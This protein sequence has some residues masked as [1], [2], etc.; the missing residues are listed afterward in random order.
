MAA[1]QSAKD[2]VRTRV[3]R[4]SAPLPRSARPGSTKRCDASPRGGSVRCPA[5]SGCDRAGCRWP[6][7]PARAR[8][9][10]AAAA[11]RACPGDGRARRAAAIQV[12]RRA[13]QH[14]AAAR[15]AA[16]A[17]AP[18]EK[19]SRKAGREPTN[20]CESPG[21]RGKTS[22]APATMI[23]SQ[24]KAARF[25]ALGRLWEGG[26]GGSSA[27]DRSGAVGGR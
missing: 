8:S 21:R 6:A 9:R 10:S 4:R 1:R 14:Q 23:S 18:S 26:L 16:R 5:P 17:G 27:R 25:S 15:T 13:R 11:P 2:S 3:R 22:T 12:A 24:R 19:R 7:S 20:R